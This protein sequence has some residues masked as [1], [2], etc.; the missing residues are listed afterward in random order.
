M[1]FNN[2]SS[3]LEIPPIENGDLVWK[4]CVPSA[5]SNAL[6]CN[7]YLLSEVS[8]AGNQTA[9]IMTT[10][11][12]VRSGA[13]GGQPIVKQ[14]WAR[15]ASVNWPA[16]GMIPFAPSASVDNYFMVQ[17]GNPLQA[18]DGSWLLP[19]YGSWEEWLLPPNTTHQN[20]REP[21]NV[22]A[23]VSVDA[24]L[25]TWQ[26]HSWVN[27]GRPW[28]CAAS[29]GGYWPLTPHNLCNPTESALS[30][31]SNGDILIVWRNDPGYNVTLMAQVSSDE[32]KSWSVAAPMHGIIKDGAFEDIVDAPFG[33]EPK[34]REYPLFSPMPR[35]LSAGPCPAFA[36]TSDND[37][38]L[39][40]VAAE[41]MAS[42]VLVLSTGRPR[43]YLW[44]LSPNADPLTAT[45]QPFDQGKIHNAAVVSMGGGTAKCGVPIFQPSYWE[46]WRGAKDPA[47]RGTG[48]CTDGYTGLVA[49]P[50]SDTLIMSYD[51]LAFNCPTGVQIPKS[52]I[53]D[54]IVSMPMKL[55]VGGVSPPAPSPP[56]PPS[57][58]PGSLTV[59]SVGAP[60]LIFGQKHVL[61]STGMAKFAQ[62]LFKFPGGQL[63]ANYQTT[64][65]VC[66]PHH[67]D[68]GRSLFSNNNGSSWQEIKAI[69]N[70]ADPDTNGLHVWKDCAPAGDGANAL[71][72]FAYYL[73][74][75]DPSDNRTAH[76][77]ITRFEVGSN[78]TVE[79]KWVKNATVDGW[80]QPGLLPFAAKTSPG[81]YYMVQDGAPIETKTKKGGEFLLPFYGVFS[82]YLIC[83]SINNCSNSTQ[84]NLMEATA[85]IALVTNTDHSFMHWKF[86]SW[87]NTGR[88]NGPNQGPRDSAGQGTTHLTGGCLPSRGTYWPA[89]DKHNTC[90]PTE[91]AMV[92]LADGR[93]LMVWRNDPGFNM[94]L[95]AQVSFDDGKT[96]SQPAVPMN[97][98]PV[99]AG[100]PGEVLV[101]GPFGVEPRLVLLPK[102]NVLLLLSGR[103]R[104]YI[105]VLPPNADPLTATW[106]PFDLGRI[107]NA[108]LA[109][110]LGDGDA[111]DKPGKFPP[112]F[113]SGWRGNGEGLMCCT[114]AYTGLV[115]VSETEVVVTYDMLDTTCPTSVT[116][117]GSNCD[118]IVSM[119]M[120]IKTDDESPSVS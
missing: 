82:E 23:L 51:M 78:Q 93:I 34:L 80:P 18:H 50:D 55:T 105:W 13:G 27:N 61:A 22:L 25:S 71:V 79:Q 56:L 62:T 111:T 14:V 17:D 41:M 15:N 120:S 52:G 49:L 26:F 110:A 33:V 87:V 116:G 10:R 64:C 114:D 42:G 21:S 99:P 20:Q 4:S 29:R 98:A 54:F 66:V 96:F 44:A 115:A 57:T 89:E 1:S 103:P 24:S 104:M 38:R 53:C 37:L 39:T 85:V 8:G 75:A 107:H 108:A 60:T 7:A 46:I 117:G 102:S 118:S 35:K 77:L 72:C 95:M 30:R 3:W 36:N 91:T 48:C 16:P 31:L 94:T 47:L 28:Q 43:M 40:I 112:Q 84:G 113:W 58:P 92:R 5:T 109:G 83:T 90:N 76:M 86:E 97:G 69:G 12:E 70:P 6:T 81:N 32:G 59:T 63:F 101:R 73:S 106:Q 100:A 9:H 11:F 119:K 45:W 88:N 68:P 67:T 65:D 19:F 2:A 74:I